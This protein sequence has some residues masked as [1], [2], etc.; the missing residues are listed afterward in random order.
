M[1]GLYLHIP[2]CK[3]ACYYC[4]FHFSTN[5]E[6]RKPMA[7]AMRNEMILQRGYLDD[8][9]LETIYLG[10]G[11]P[12]LLIQSELEG[13]FEQIHKVFSVNNDAEITAEVNPDDLT[14][15]KIGLLK[16]VGV[17]RLS[18]GVQS[19]SDEVLHFFNRAHHAEE[20]ILGF[21]RAR[22]SGFENIS[23]DLIYG[24]PGQDDLTW[25]KII[26]RAIG[27]NPEH[28]S[29]YS[30]T[31]EED[32][33]FG[34]WQARN[35]FEAM[36]EEL[37]AR[38]FELLMIS[39]E[40]AGY[41]HYE[42]SNFAKAGYFSKHNSSYWQQKKYLGIGP[43]AHSFNHVSRQF[44]IRNNAQYIKSIQQGVVPFELEK[45]TKSDQVNEYFLTTL[46]TSWG[47]DLAYLAN[48]LN[49][50]L[51]DDQL[52]YVDQLVKN[53]LATKDATRLRLTRKG[54]LLADK[55]ASDLFINEDSIQNG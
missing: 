33:V 11:T 34:R 24:V 36:E 52:S 39:L 49:Y 20:A 7:E 6:L 5:Q 27:L 4:D 42:I 44:N 41:E 53:N 28:I 16:S 26:D 3:Q 54:K 9:S 50:R 8:E 30:L 45:L 13:L 22:E 29:A 48:E 32:T 15:E 25:G 55:I 18:I 51:T 38:Q 21:E 40:K 31:I 35:K 2:F 46:R 23:L 43:S 47:C 19:F 1:A 10:G 12:S 17:N 37:V 14:V